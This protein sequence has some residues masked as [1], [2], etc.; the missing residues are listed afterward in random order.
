MSV[1][2]F[3]PQHYTSTLGPGHRKTVF[4]RLVNNLHRD[5]E[6]V[7]KGWH[8]VNYSPFLQGTEKKVACSISKKEVG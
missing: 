1:L 6:L 5:K 7:H 8:I 2:T 4:I 3:L